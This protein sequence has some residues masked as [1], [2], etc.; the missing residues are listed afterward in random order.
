MTE[1]ANYYSGIITTLSSKI[2][3]LK[4]PIS[5]KKDQLLNIVCIGDS[6]TAATTGFIA[7]KRYCD[8]L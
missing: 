1:L 7:T 3:I 5:S 4:K 6:N 2:H 8:L